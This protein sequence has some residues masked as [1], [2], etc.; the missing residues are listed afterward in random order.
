MK[1]Q[2]VLLKIS[3]ESLSGSEAYGINKEALHFYAS[4]I[5]TAYNLGLQIGVVIGGGNIFRGVQGAAQGH[6]RIQGDYMGMLATVINSMALE[7]ELQSINVK[8]VVLS[9]LAIDP[10]CEKMSSQRAIEYLKNDYVVIMGGGTGNPFFTTDS[11]GALRALE[12][13]ADLLLKGT[14]VDGVYNKDPE[15]HNDAVKFNTLTF[16]EAYDKGLNIMDLT[17]FTLCKENNLPIVV[18]NMNQKD[19]LSKILKGEKIGTLISN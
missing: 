15:K 1:Y 13:K 8:A 6:D 18:F 7:S 3:G 9:G 17:A 10:L 19:N 11:T 5:K 12:I 4:E 16:N 2:R 14:R